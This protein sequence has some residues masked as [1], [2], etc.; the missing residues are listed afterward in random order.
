MIVAVVVACERPGSF[1]RARQTAAKQDI[2][3]LRTALISYKFDV[4]SYPSSEQGLQALRVK[5]AGVNKWQGPYLTKDVPPDPWG[6]PFIYKYPGDHGEDPDI[7][8][9]GLDGQPGGEGENADI[10][11]WK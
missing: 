4:G 9:L 5:P 11:S 6:R 2:D 7:S 8:S 1:S 3:A 10:V